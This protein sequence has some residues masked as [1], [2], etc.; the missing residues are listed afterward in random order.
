MTPRL[1]F[2]PLDEYLSSVYGDLSL[3]ALCRLLRADHDAVPVWRIEGLTW[4]HADR[5]AVRAGT[6]VWNVW[7]QQWAQV[8]DDLDDVEVMA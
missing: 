8:C 3:T 7:G 5:L 1:P 2:E 4:D 6:T